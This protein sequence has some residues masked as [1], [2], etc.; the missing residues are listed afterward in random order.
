MEKFSFQSFC[1]DRVRYSRRASVHCLVDAWNIYCGWQK[2]NPDKRRL[3]QKKFRHYIE[4]TFPYCVCQNQSI[5]IH[6]FRTDQECDDYDGASDKLIELR[7]DII[8]ALDIRHP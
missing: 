4:R 6:Y 5:H 3:S 7:D 8:R 1:G 2:D